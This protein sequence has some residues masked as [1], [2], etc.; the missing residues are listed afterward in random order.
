MFNP[1]LTDPKDLTDAELTDKINAV[2]ER[3]I[4][5][6]SMGNTSAYRQASDIYFEYQEAMRDRA[7][8]RYN[9]SEDDFSD[10]IDIKK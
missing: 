4:F 7:T 2:Y 9:T 1:L 3:M 6:Q 10:K 5:F 8:E